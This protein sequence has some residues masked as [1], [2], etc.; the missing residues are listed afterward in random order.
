MYCLQWRADPKY[1]FSGHVRS[2]VTLELISISF[3]TETMFEQSKVAVW[4]LLQGSTFVFIGLLSVLEYF[5]AARKYIALRDQLRTSLLLTGL[6]FI[7][8]MIAG[9][10]WYLM[11]SL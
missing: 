6:F 5:A 11:R 10:A 1:Q 9:N 4:A 8:W 2:I 3:E 7:A